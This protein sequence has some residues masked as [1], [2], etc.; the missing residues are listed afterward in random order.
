MPVGWGKWKIWNSCLPRK[1]LGCFGGQHH[2]SF[3]ELEHWEQTLQ[4]KLTYIYLCT[5]HLRKELQHSYKQNVFKTGSWNKYYEKEN[6]AT[7]LKNRQANC[8]KRGP[9]RT[10]V[11]HLALIS[12]GSQGK[13]G[14][15]MDYKII[16]CSKE[17]SSLFRRAAFP[18]INS[19]G[20]LLPGPPLYWV[21][22]NIMD[23]ITMTMFAKNTAIA[24]LWMLLTN[25]Q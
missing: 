11:L 6:A 17:A 7:L 20:N 10:R 19:K 15:V 8:I 14:A 16:G 9:A 24:F 25:L 13:Q 4:V 22:N 5:G 2:F 21:M 3:L 23:N 1:A 18:L 12:T